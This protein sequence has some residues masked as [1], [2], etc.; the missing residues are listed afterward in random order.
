MSVKTP[1]LRY[2]R[3][4]LDMEDCNAR[5]YRDT[6]NIV[7]TFPYCITPPSPNPSPLRPH[8]DYTSNRNGPCDIECILVF[9]TVLYLVFFIAVP[10]YCYHT[11]SAS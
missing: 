1:L 2:C 5:A 10:L 4:A 6:Q 7:Q 11:M 9:S 8:Y 3:K